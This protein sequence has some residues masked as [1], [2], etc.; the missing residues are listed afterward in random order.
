MGRSNLILNLDLHTEKG[1][2]ADVDDDEDECDDECEFFLPSRKPTVI[3]GWEVER[4]EVDPD[5]GGT[6]SRGRK[7]KPNQS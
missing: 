3:H 1:V 4:Q 7:I 2:F 5:T 6:K